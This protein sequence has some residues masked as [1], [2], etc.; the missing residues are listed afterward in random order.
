MAELITISLRDA[1]RRLALSNRANETVAFGRL[2]ALLKSGQ[3]QAGFQFPLQ[4]TVAYIRIPTHYWPTVSSEKFKIIRVAKSNP[5]SGAYKVKI[6][7]FPAEVAAQ[8]VKTVKPER[9]DEAWQAIL[10][11]TAQA[12]EVVILESDWSA[13][14]QSCPMLPVQAVRKSNAGRKEKEGWRDLIDFVGAYIV[15]HYQD[16]KE[17]IKSDPAAERIRNLAHDAGVFDLPEKS[18]ISDKLDKI[19]QIARTIDIR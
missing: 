15:K 16:S 5:R 18:T 10:A 1:G 12:Y 14:E 7:Q 2:L 6:R 4:D 19:K 17:P 9:R 8:V 3:I 11:A 13:Y